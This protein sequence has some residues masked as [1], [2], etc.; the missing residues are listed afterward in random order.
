MKSIYHGTLLV[1]TLC[2]S[3]GIGFVPETT[4]PLN[5]SKSTFTFP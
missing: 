4:I 2:K 3:T 5:V 1:A